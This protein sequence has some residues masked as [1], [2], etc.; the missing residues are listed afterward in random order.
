MEPNTKKKNKKGG[1]NTKTKKSL[2]AQ[3]G[4]FFD[5]GGRLV[6]KN[7]CGEKEEGR[8]WGTRDFRV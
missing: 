4:V 1:I 3:E 8:W 5:S 7:K 6:N 2:L